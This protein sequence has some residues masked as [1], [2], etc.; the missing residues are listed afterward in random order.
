[1]QCYSRIVTLMGPTGCGQATKLCNQTIVSA[2]LAAIAEAVVLASKSG[3]DANKL[4]DALS[5]GWADSVLL[6]T[7]APRMASPDNKILGRAGLLL[8]DAENIRR[9]AIDSSTDMPVAS[10][11]LRLLQSV[12]ENGFAEKDISS[13]ASFL[14]ARNREPL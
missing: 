2:T 14:R 9:A 13:I 12:C 4:A 11:V 3:V 1:V 5:G 8:K 7:F 6:K 10:A